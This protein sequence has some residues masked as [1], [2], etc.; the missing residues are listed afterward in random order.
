VPTLAIDR[1][2]REGASVDSFYTANATCSPSRAAMMTGRY[3]TRFG[4]EFTA[5]P[6][7]FAKNLA[8]SDR[9]APVKP[10]FHADKVEGIMPYDQ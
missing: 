6:P 3:P 4:F 9:E 5:V 10:I 8:H 1:L 2:K 7:V